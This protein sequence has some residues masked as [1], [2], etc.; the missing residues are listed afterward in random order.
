MRIT[1]EMNLASLKTHAEPEFD[2]ICT[3]E[4]MHGKTDYAWL[5]EFGVLAAFRDEVVPFI[6]GRLSA[7][8]VD[9]DAHLAGEPREKTA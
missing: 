9:D 2:I 7:L 3:I 1:I 5:D 6:N 8:P 4:D